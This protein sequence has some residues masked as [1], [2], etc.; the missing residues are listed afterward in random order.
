MHAVGLGLEERARSRQSIRIKNGANGTGAFG[1]N[2]RLAIWQRKGGI[3][4]P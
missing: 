4:D 2:W 1:H 3:A